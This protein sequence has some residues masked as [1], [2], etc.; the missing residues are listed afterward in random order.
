[1][2]CFMG[3][4]LKFFLDHVYV[5]TLYGVLTSVATRYSPLQNQAYLTVRKSCKTGNGNI[6]NLS[7]FLYGIR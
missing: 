2:L 3:I 6:L 1:M 4:F 5:T 7:Y